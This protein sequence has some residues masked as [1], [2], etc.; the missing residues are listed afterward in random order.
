[1]RLSRLIAGLVFVG[2]PLAVATSVHARSS[3]PERA[4][5]RRI[6]AHFDSVLIELDA[7]DVARLSP[8]QKHRRAQL[9]ATLAAYRD[10]GV[11]PHNYDFPDRA[12][13]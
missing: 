5:I 6:R 9:V 2:A 8:D 12:M 13:P 7:R 4:E 3:D 10:R 11:F 1:M